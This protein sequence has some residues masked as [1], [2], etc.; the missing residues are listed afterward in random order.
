MREY[1]GMVHAVAR[2]IVG[3]VA[4]ADDVVQDTFLSA[5]RTWKSFRGESDPGTWLYRVAVR[6]AGRLLRRKGRRRERS[7]SAEDIM[8]FAN[9]RLPAMPD[10]FQS[11]AAKRMRDEAR[12][13][14]NEAIATLPT[15]FRMAVVLKDIAELPL[16][17]ISA[18]LDVKVATVKTRVHRGRLMLRAAL[19]ADLNRVHVPPAVYERSMCM[20]LLRAKMEAL[21]HG[22]AFPVQEA[23]ICERCQNVF[24]SLDLGF[25]ACQH[26]A[27][28]ADLPP[29]VRKLVLAEIARDA[30]S[31]R[32]KQRR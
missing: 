29:E 13:E 6:A 31:P 22:V 14:V 21:D 1:G 7:W 12:D 23:L 17:Q 2:R 5:F 26:A 24:L 30:K 19:V 25:D 27:R 32:R 3:T 18:I 8:P 20:D 10:D 16:E 4:E 28:D 11:P 9:A 15:P